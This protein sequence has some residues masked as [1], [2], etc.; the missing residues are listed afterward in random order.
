MQNN[1]L[2]LFVSKP[3]CV[4]ELGPVTA[5]FSQ[6]PL[7][8]DDQAISLLC[9]GSPDLTP[10]AEVGR[11]LHRPD[12][13]ARVTCHPLRS[14]LFV[15]WWE[16]TYEW[17][18]SI[19]TPLGSRRRRPGLSRGRC[20]RG[21]G[22]AAEQLGHKIKEEEIITVS[23]KTEGEEAATW[24][25]EC[26][27]QKQQYPSRALCYSVSLALQAPQAVKMEKQENRDHDISDRDTKQLCA[28]IREEQTKELV[29]AGMANNAAR[30]HSQWLF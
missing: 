26:A 16:G 13:R 30:R 21:P 10:S 3:T 27:E 5:A 29:R 20:Q 23:A 1:L 12:A 22:Q 28:M 4:W 18:N 24:A 2:L 8:T 15:K 17:Q 7:L 14:D 6:Y 19:T 11:D 25:A 9:E